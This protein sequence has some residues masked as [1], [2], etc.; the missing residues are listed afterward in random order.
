MRYQEGCF[1]VLS[2]HSQLELKGDETL[3]IRV[4]GGS[5]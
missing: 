1:Q 2:F 5:Y 4:G 3:G